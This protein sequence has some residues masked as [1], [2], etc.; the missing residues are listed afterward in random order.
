MGNDRFIYSDSREGTEIPCYIWNEMGV[1][2]RNK[3]TGEVNEFS[4]VELVYYC[5]I[6]GNKEFILSEDRR[7]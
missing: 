6:I 3:E 5:Q 7:G 2:A 4:K 1:K